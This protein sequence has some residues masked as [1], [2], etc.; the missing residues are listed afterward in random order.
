MKQLKLNL[1]YTWHKDNSYGDV[2]PIKLS[3]YSEIQDVIT[4]TLIPLKAYYQSDRAWISLNKGLE[5][6]C[7]NYGWDLHVGEMITI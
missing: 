2:M 3:L 1:A 7:L 5:V 4:M 6:P